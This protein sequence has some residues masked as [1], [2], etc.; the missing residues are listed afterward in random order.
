[1]DLNLFDRVEAALESIRPYLQTDGGDVELLEITANNVANIKLM[2]AC[3][4]CSMS[5]MT[6]KLGI[7]KAILKAVPQITAVYAMPS[8]S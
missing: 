5:H 8:S 7:E 1:M 3:E 6:M 2:G 4:S